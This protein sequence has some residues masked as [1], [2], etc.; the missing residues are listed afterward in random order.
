MADYLPY[1]TPVPMRTKPPRTPQ[2]RDPLDVPFLQ[3]AIIG[4]ADLLVT[5]DKD[6]LAVRGRI[7]C[8]IVPAEVFLLTR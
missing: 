8:P 1:C 4:N 5:G 6:L 2:C 7:S 3:L